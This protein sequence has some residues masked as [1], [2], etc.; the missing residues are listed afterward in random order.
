MRFD[1]RESATLLAALGACDYHAPGLTAH[2]IQHSLQGWKS[3]GRAEL[4][5]L[6][7]TCRAHAAELGNAVARESS[8]RNSSRRHTFPKSRSAFSF[9]DTHLQYI[10]PVQ[11]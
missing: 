10:C 9:S 3:L 7:E 1:K 6:E 8:N 2:V 4:R 11:Q 5:K